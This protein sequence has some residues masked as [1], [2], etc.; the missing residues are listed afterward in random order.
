MTHS[1]SQ[2][3]NNN[4]QVD[5]FNYYSP[6]NHNYQVHP[7][8]YNYNLQNSAQFYSYPNSLSSPNHFENDN[9]YEVTQKNYY[10]EFNDE[11]QNVE[12]QSGIINIDQLKENIKIESMA[13]TKPIESSSGV[14]TS[15]ETDR[16]DLTNSLRAHTINCNNINF[17]YPTEMKSNP[18]IK[19]N[20]QD[21]ELWN[22]FS[23][24]GTEM[25]ITKAGRR[26]FPTIRLNV[27]GLNPQ[28]KYI[29]FI[30]IVPK[31]DNRYKYSK[32]EWL[33][34]GKAEPHFNGL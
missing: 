16:S 14:K 6:Y 32:A 4:S 29:M 1:P 5:S 23:E 28:S 17:K 19:L 10:Q 21:Q 34:A 20:M 33:V 3:Y 2:H 22:Q 7:S 27:S 31:D 11:G 15:Q 9:S 8:Y 26:M 13:S 25:I 30:D 12:S 18:N 24:L